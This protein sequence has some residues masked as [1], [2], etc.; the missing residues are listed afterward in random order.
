MFALPVKICGTKLEP[1]ITLHVMY[2]YKN[3]HFI[4]PELAQITALMKVMKH[5]L[6][7]K[8]DTAPTPK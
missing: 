4:S 6:S 8:H 3:I 2:L 7:D 5:T 1:I